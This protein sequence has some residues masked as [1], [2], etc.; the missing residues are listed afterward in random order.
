MAIL[1]LIIFQAI[2]Q[3]F[4]PQLTFWNMRISILVTA[5]FAFTLTLSSCLSSP[6]PKDQATGCPTR[7]RGVFDIGSGST[8]LTLAEV[9]VCGEKVETIRILDDESSFDAAL[10]LGKSQYGTLSSETQAQVVDGINRLIQTSLEKGKT[11][12]HKSIEFAAA[13]TQAVRSARNKKEFAAKIRPVAGN[14]TVLTQRQEAHFGYQGVVGKGAPIA[15]EGKKLWVWDMGGGS[16]QL[17]GPEDTGLYLSQQGAE[18]FKKELLYK[19]KRKK[20]PAGCKVATLTPNPLGASGTEIAARIARESAQETLKSL[21]PLN[22]ANT[23][24]VG[25]G[26][27]HNKA[28]E[29]NIRKFWPKIQKCVCGNSECEHTPSTY[30]FNEVKCLQE[31]LSSKSDCDEEIAGPYSTTT[32]SNLSLVM[33]FLEHM[34]KPTIHTMNVNMGHPLVQSL[35][36]LDFQPVAIPRP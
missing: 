28:V 1:Q 8:K 35:G 5:S 16:Q 4:I 36:V 24:V 25:I 2:G 13:G 12:E 32:V 21:A 7:L 31:H 14:L 30:T 22:G 3:G 6:R 15:C 18:G 10:E 33:G 9:R 26:G 17:T 19:M 27:V 23:C 20:N 34:G 11:T 29:A